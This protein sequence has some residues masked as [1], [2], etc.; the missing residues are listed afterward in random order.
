MS[1]KEVT[2]S[3]ERFVECIKACN[4]CA[5]ACEHCAASCLQEANP[6]EMARCIALDIDCA[7]ICHLAAAYMGRGSELAST[8]CATCAEVC[9]TCAEE[10]DKHPMHH[11]KDCAQACR[12]CAQECRRMAHGAKTGA[13]RSAGARPAH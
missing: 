11:C 1:P 5:L 7:E 12:R 4:D 9:E 2:M 6:K 13:E 8:I 10:C 3:H